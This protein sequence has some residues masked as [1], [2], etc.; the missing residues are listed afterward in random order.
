MSD[1]VD[2]TLCAKTLPST[3]Q[4]PSVAGSPAFEQVHAPLRGVG[5]L[6]VAI[7]LSDHLSGFPLC[8][9]DTASVKPKDGSTNA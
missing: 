5:D 9:S 6:Q 7:A 8:C 2:A 1:Q 3:R 4:L